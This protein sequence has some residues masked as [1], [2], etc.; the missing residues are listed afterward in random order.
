MARAAGQDDRERFARGRADAL[1]ARVTV[2][3]L[4]VPKQGMDGVELSIDGRAVPKLAWGEPMP[5]AVPAS[6]ER[7]AQVHSPLAATRT[8]SLAAHSAFT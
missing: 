3:V 7:P 8:P 5:R 1:K 2:V 4:T 6:T